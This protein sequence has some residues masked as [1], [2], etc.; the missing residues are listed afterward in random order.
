MTATSLLIAA[1]ITFGLRFGIL[2][3]R[4]FEDL[5]RLAGVFNIGF[6][7]GQ[8]APFAPSGIGVREAIV[9]LLLREIGSTNLRLMIELVFT[10]RLIWM[11]ADFL[12]LLPVTILRRYNRFDR[13]FF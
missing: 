9:S 8:L 6:S 10:H 3:S 5:I 13:E 2:F 12:V 7:V 11:V 1:W 4:G